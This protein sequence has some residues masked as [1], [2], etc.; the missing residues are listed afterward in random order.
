MLV[1]YRN[2]AEMHGQQN[3]KDLSPVFSCDEK[4]GSIEN[5]RP[6]PDFQ[7]HTLNLQYKKNFY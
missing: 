3:I 6:T 4:V 1:I 5:V 2:Y 7:I